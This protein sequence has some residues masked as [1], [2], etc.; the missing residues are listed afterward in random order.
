MGI[1][2]LKLMDENLSVLLSIC[3]LL[4]D[5]NPDKPLVPEIAMSTKGTG[6]GTHVDC[7]NLQ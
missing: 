7:L 1:A 3:S 2:I 6:L 4:D 5:P